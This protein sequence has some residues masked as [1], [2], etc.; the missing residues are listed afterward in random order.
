MQLEIKIWKEQAMISLQGMPKNGLWL[1][2]N[3]VIVFFL[4]LST[5]FKTYVKN[6]RLHD[7]DIAFDYWPILIEAQNF[8]EN[9]ELKIPTV[10]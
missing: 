7:Y 9:S 3:L 4:S 2:W 1:H 5:A 10:Y 6:L 8:N